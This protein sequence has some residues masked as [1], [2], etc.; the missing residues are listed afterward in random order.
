MEA[1]CRSKHARQVAA[2]Q[3][4]QQA[5]HTGKADATLMS[6]L[7]KSDLGGFAE[8]FAWPED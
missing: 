2:L 8:E 6:G 4:R 7:G 5:V 3:Q 1:L